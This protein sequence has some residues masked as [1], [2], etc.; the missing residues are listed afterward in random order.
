MNCREFADNIS[1]YIDNEM[2]EIEKKEF[3][4]HILECNNCR[5]EYE[6]MIKILKN[7]KNQEQVDL[8]DNYRLELRRKL[9]EAAKEEKRI[10]WRVISSIAAGLIIMIISISMFSD[11]LPFIG[12]GQYLN[13]STKDE[14]QQENIAFDSNDSMIAKENENM[15]IKAFTSRDTDNTNPTVDSVPAKTDAKEDISLTQ[16]FGVM[17]SRSSVGGKARKTIKE[18]YLSIDLEGSDKIQEQIANY[19]EENGGF[20]ENIDEVAVENDTVTKQKSHLIKIRIPT[21]K[22]DK[23]L[24]FLKQLGTLVD[25]KLDQ[26]DITEQYSNIESNLRCL[27]EQESLLLEILYKVKDTDDK[28]LVENKLNKVKDE[29]NSETSILEEYDDSVILSTINTRLNDADKDD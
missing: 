11:K 6:D 13:K 29:I 24:D 21:D 18:A 10:N 4:L 3:E 5:Q 14:S 2:T 12:D 20:V 25:E 9:K 17:A 16:S 26:N 19:V 23:T 22:F 8:P 15:Q 1:S 28:L 7:I 27:Y